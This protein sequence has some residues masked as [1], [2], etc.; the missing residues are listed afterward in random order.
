MSSDPPAPGLEPPRSLLASLGPGLLWAGTAVGVSHLVQST[1]AGAGYGFALVWIVLVANLLK[2]PAFEAAP[3]YTA[4]T[5]K[6]LLYGYR[7]QGRWVL[8]LFLGLTVA[9]MFTVVAAVT[10]VTAGMAS[11]L[12][13]DALP[14]IAWSAIL[15]VGAGFLLGTGSFRLLEGLMKVM[16]LLLSVSTLLC[17]ALLATQV[18]VSAIPWTPMIPEYSAANVAFIVALVGWMPTAIDMSVWQSLWGLEK[19]R[20]E[21]H[22]LDFR[23]SM[24]D[25][26]VGY[27]GTAILALCF[28]FLGA[29][30]L[31][32]SGR[33]IPNS[34]GAF[35]VLF[36]DLYAQALGDWSRPF[37]L[38]AA[39]TTMLSTTIACADGFPR[40]L[41][42]AVTEIKGA[43][44]APGE[45][46]MIYWVA[47]GVVGVGALVLIAFF[48]KNLKG[49]VDLA[50]TLSFLTAPILAYFNFRVVTSAEVPVE[51][52][53]GR[54]LLVLHVVGILFTGAL[55]AYYVYVKLGA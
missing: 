6:S 28:V 29:A 17:V 48:A 10:I 8:F 42:A 47:L 3:R 15:L 25:F 22:R 26:Y 46:T 24:F 1:R 4:A 55:A 33:E 23:G 49:L 36:V 38:V 50:T 5:G 32:G 39:F 37:V 31:H 41:E 21:G 35:A 30:V 9:T 19:S 54:G 14:P 45:R 43:N 2:Y 20:N 51:R 16:M 27:L 44:D 52:R 11:A 53:P 40:A 34:G 7:D 13:T 12:V 18:D